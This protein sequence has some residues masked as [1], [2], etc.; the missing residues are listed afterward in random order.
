MWAGY[1]EALGVPGAPVDQVP[2]PRQAA[3]GVTATD[4]ISEIS[5]N[6]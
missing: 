4:E 2:T 3:L 1:G 6:V 5:N